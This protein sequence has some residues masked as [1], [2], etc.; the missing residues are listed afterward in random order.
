MDS[1]IQLIIT[2]LPYDIGKPQSAAI[3]ETLQALEQDREGPWPIDWRNLVFTE[4]VDP[5]CSGT[6]ICLSWAEEK[7][8]D[9]VNLVDAMGTAHEALESEGYEVF[10]GE[11]RDRPPQCGRVPAVRRSCRTTTR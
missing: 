4:E 10:W 5:G 8:M 11:R 3:S 7:W 6:R 9:D 2:H 1:P